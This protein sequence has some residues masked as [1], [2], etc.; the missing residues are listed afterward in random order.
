M[1]ARVVL[2][3]ALLLAMAAAPVAAQSAPESRTVRCGDSAWRYV[4]YVPH[5]DG[6]APVLVLLHGAGDVPEAMVDVWRGLAD[7]EGIVLVA[8]ALPRVAAFEGVAPAVFRC[9]VDQ[10]GRLTRVDPRRVYLFGHSM[11]GYLAYDAA[12]LESRYFAAAAVHGMALA[13]DYAWI[14]GKAERKTPIVIYAGDRDPYAT[15]AAVEWTRDTLAASGCP[16]RL[17]EMPG[18]DHDYGA[19]ADSVDRDAWRFLSAWRLPAP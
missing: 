7:A 16:V 17:V 19:V 2:P 18:H 14:I 4:L 6:P 11:G 3:A 8:P 9:A 12:L 15:P 10:A 1:T 13:R 5:H